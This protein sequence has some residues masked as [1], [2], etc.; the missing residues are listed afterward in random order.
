MN[1]HGRNLP[2]FQ[3]LRTTNVRFENLSIKY[4]YS[5]KT[6]KLKENFFLDKGDPTKSMSRS[7]MLKI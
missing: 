4:L 1:F 3:N 6:W 7:Y 2:F 5:S